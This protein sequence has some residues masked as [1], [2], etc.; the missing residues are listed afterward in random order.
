MDPVR[1]GQLLIA[2]SG[3]AALAL[4]LR[5]RPQGRVWRIG[6]LGYTSASSEA[7]ALHALRAS[8]RELGYAEGG[9]ILIEYRFADGNFDRLPELAAE[10]VRQKVDLIV[11]WASP[12]VRAAKHATATI[13]IVMIASA[14]AVATGLVASLARPGGN[15]TGLTI[16][17]PEMAVKRLELLKEAVPRI[18]RVAVLVRSGN[19]ANDHVI[20]AMER[21]AKAL[22]VALR[23]LSVRGPNEFQNAFAEMASARADALV[24]TDDP[25]LNLHAKTFAG[26]AAGWRLPSAYTPAIADAGGLIG[27]GTIAGAGSRSAASYVDKI[28][29]GAN[30]ADLPVEQPTKFELVI[31][32][33]TARALGI[34]I[35]QS[36]LLRADRLIE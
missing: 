17:S 14:D 26:M 8:L 21:A 31:N 19:P 36:V 9:N 24:V 27:Y 13:P 2:I 15:V 34:K 6:Y 7:T 1:R 12:A 18:V 35:A 11:T 33:K 16:L 29:K 3:L 10:L 23:Q 4:P 30:P 28:L 5:A 22:D 25:M 20:P 32:L